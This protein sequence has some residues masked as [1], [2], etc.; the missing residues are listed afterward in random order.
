MSVFRNHTLFME[1]AKN[2]YA[3]PVRYTSSPLA[4]GYISDDN[5]EKLAGTAAVQVSSHGSGRVISLVDDPNF[6]A[7]WYGTN[8]LFLNSIFYGHLI[9]GSTT[10]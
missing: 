9:S 3:N 6:R 5:L 1:P 8:K 4:S 7:F 10:E 2:P